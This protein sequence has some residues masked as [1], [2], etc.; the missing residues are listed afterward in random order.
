MFFL[1]NVL[2]GTE[3]WSLGASQFFDRI[4]RMNRIEQNGPKCLQSKWILDNQ[5]HPENCREQA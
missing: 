5:T 1:A 3:S 4:Y 2:D